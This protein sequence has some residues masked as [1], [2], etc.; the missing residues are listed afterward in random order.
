MQGHAPALPKF[1]GYIL[2]S[3]QALI[4]GRRHLCRSQADIIPKDTQSCL[5]RKADSPREAAAMLAMFTFRWQAPG[6]STSLTEAPLITDM[7]GGVH[8]QTRKYLVPTT[9][10]HARGVSAP[11]GIRTSNSPSTYLSSHLTS[12]LN[13]DVQQLQSRSSP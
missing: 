4:S 9:L 5:S 7:I 1:V 10:M 11:S 8:K 6:S 13:L 12:F 2:I 3:N